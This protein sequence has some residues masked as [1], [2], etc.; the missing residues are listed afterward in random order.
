MKTLPY[1]LINGFRGVGQP[2]IDLQWKNKTNKVE[3]SIGQEQ[4]TK[5]IFEFP[6]ELI[7]K[8]KDGTSMLKTFAVKKKNQ[9][10]TIPVKS[11]VTDIIIDPNILL[12]YKTK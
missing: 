6:L 1:F 3:I 4:K 10:F 9:I 2:E 5:T 8:Y 11:P 12:L 7:I